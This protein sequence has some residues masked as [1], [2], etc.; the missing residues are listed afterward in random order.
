MADEQV[1]RRRR[2]R[3][4]GEGEGEGGKRETLSAALTTL[5]FRD[6]AND[7]PAESARVVGYTYIYVCIYACMWWYRR[8]HTFV[9]S[10]ALS[11]REPRAGTEEGERV[12][13]SRAFPSRER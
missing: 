3:G 12:D 4:E 9:K 11:P 8:A 5:L 2:G 6:A 7:P 1:S 13:R 10:A